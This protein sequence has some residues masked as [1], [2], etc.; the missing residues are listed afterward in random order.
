LFRTH[1]VRLHDI[2]LLII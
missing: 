2:D 1:F